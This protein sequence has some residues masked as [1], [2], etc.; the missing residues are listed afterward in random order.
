MTGALLTISENSLARA[1]EEQQR[2]MMRVAP[3]I[4]QMTQLADRINESYAP[5]FKTI[6]ALAESM[7]P[8]L[9]T[10]ARLRESVSFYSIPTVEYPS[11][12]FTQTEVESKPEVTAAKLVTTVRIPDTDLTFDARQAILSK[13][14]SNVRRVYAFEDKGRRRLFVRLMSARQP[15]ATE[16]LREELGRNS[17]DAIRKMVQGING[18]ARKQ[19]GIKERIVIARRGSGYMLNPEVFIHRT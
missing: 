5:M 6:Q 8:T 7:R 3:A 9:E 14:V 19:L 16:T 12:I 1:F 11:R 2:A 4:A 18:E 15:I 17:T 10:M 13:T